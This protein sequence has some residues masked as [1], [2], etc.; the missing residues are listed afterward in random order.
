MPIARP[1]G[2]APPEEGP[3]ARSGS[4]RTW[5]PRSPAPRRENFGL[6]RLVNRNP[7]IVKTVLINGKLA[8]DDEQ[9][10]PEFGREMG[11]G[12]FIPAR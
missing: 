4:T 12:R 8:V 1:F 9:L 11:Y 7:G 3:T 5:S 6:Q 2:G 10:V